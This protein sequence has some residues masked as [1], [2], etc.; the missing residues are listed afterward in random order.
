MRRTLQVP[1]AIIIALASTTAPA[2]AQDWRKAI[3]SYLSR[4]GLSSG[5][6]QAVWNAVKRVE[7]EREKHL[8]KQRKEDQKKSMEYIKDAFERGKKAFEERRYSAAYLHFMDVA[9]SA[10]GPAA[11]MAA[12][13]KTKAL[14]IEAMA[15][16]RLEQAKVFLLQ[17]QPLPAAELLQ[18]IAVEFPFCDA[19]GQAKSRLQSLR[20]IPSVA[21][22]MRYG[23]G[24]AQE[25][26]EIFGE[27]LAIY[28]Q[29]VQKWPGELAALRARVAAEAI[30]RDATKMAAVTESKLLEADRACP[31]LINIAKSFMMNYEGLK[32][33]ESPDPDALTELRLQA[34]E[35]L[36]QVVRE[37]PGTKYAQEAA[38]LLEAIE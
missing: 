16:A 12:E 25:D 8:Q 6:Q 33:T 31:T 23:E 18:Q 38:E 4:S 17:N 1:A 21:A 28:D 7:R 9:K 30:R 36:N 10:L 3:D 19:A 26:A 5:Q 24:K 13:A 20:S 22:S 11:K 27:A 29:V 14:E 2:S 34:T 37:Y 15:L 35:K 32:K